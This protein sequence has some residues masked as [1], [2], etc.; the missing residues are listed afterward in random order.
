MH[1][2]CLHFN[3]PLK[4]KQWLFA[5]TDYKH[6][7]KY[8]TKLPMLADWGRYETDINM[9]TKLQ[10]QNFILLT[11]HTLHELKTSLFVAGLIWLETPPPRLLLWLK[12]TWSY[13]VKMHQ[14]WFELS[15]RSGE[16][17]WL[18]PCGEQALFSVLKQD[19][20]LVIEGGHFRFRETL[21]ESMNFINIL[22]TNDQDDLA[23]IRTHSENF[24][25]THPGIFSFTLTLPR[26]SHPEEPLESRQ[27][28]SF[29]KIGAELGQPKSEVDRCFLFSSMESCLH[30]LWSCTMILLFP[31]S[32]VGM[33]WRA[34]MPVLTVGFAISSPSLPSA[35]VMSLFSCF[36]Q[37]V[38]LY[39]FF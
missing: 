2:A 8:T 14:L 29:I 17:Q 38:L 12:K 6:C 3:S 27:R 13:P 21:Q 7:L 31:T 32:Q 5:V 18:R 24:S 22:L 15:M 26:N 16:K 28:Y 4:I 11:C 25:V 37:H 33:R 30:R 9:V 36:T 34:K 10:T 1:S 20:F 39:V 19:K 23:I 35:C